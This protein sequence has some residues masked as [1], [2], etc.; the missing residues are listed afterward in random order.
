MRRNPTSNIV[1]N[2][3]NVNQINQNQANPLKLPQQSVTG[4]QSFQDKIRDL[5][6]EIKSLEQTVLG[7]EKFL[8]QLQISGTEQTTLD[9][10]RQNIQDKEIEIEARK[11]ELNIYQQMLPT[12]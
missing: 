1:I 7:M 8:K 11:N 10:M 5:N 12:I 9:L 6:L 3:T 4:K 2:S